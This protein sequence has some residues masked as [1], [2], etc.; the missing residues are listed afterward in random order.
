MLKKIAGLFLFSTIAMSSFASAA[1][2][3]PMWV[4]QLNNTDMNGFTFGVGAS[5]SSTHGTGIVHCHSLMGRDQV[6]TPVYVRLFGLGAGLGFA[7]ITN[8]NI[9]VAAVG[10]STPNDLFGDFRI[11]GE[12]S[13]IVL[14]NGANLNTYAAI[15]KSGLSIGVG[16]TNY[17]GYGFDVNAEL[18]GITIRPVESQY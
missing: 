9:A 17:A 12:I 7:E 15:N 10:V 2:S 16:M 11:Q 13:A 4:C 5:V 18:Q 3:G 6:D 8:M 14:E 1:V